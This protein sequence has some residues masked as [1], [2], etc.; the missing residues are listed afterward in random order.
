MPIF[1]PASLQRQAML[2]A[3]D[4]QGTVSPQQDAQTPST[5]IP[6]DGLA[7]FLAGQGLDMGTTIAA[8]QNPALREANPLGAGGTLA[9]KAAFLLGGPL[10]MK[11]MAS[12]G[13]PTAARVAGYLG[14][15]GG[16]IPGVMNL[17]TMA[18]QK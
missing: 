8:L 4:Q 2:A 5:G 6:K 3:L 15:I 17:R 9:A 13:H 11:Y 10:L 18:Q 12:H 14:G 1:D 7:A 16:A